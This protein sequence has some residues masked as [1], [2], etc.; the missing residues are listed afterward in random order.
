MTAL[1]VAIGFT[2]G[3]SALCSVLEA[4]ILSTTT[5]EIESLKRTKPRLGELLEHFRNDLEETTSAILSLNTIANTLGATL[6]GGL[7][8][9]L[10]GDNKL[11]YFSL[12]MTIG[13]LI[14]SEVIPKNIGVIYRNGIQPLLI[15]PLQL[16]R[17]LMRPVSKLCKIAVYLVVPK[18]MSQQDI[19]DDDIRFLAEKSEKDG[20][21]TQDERV[22][23]SNA[24]SLDETH[25]EEI[26]TPRT[27]VMALEQSLTIKEVF[28]TEPNLPF[29]RIPVYRNSIDTITGMVRRRDLLKSK[30][31]DNDQL[32]VS[33]LMNEPIFVLGSR[34]AA[35]ALQLFLKK[36]QQLAIVLDEY[37]SVEGVIAMED[38]IEHIL[39]KEIFEIDDVA[40]DMR[41]YAKIQNE[42]KQLHEN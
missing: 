2:I 6:V 24:L 42:Q 21:L 31:D 39:G 7:A 10:F 30:A 27:V 33:D 35:D 18:R 16:I 26:M 37:G 19:S 28:E 12:G 29:A 8:A 15:R 5:S 40:I 9:N 14:F 11:V 41:E 1:I 23:I 25:I 34:T 36:N 17:F 32:K 13:I 38:V 22:I 4:M 20:N 3:V